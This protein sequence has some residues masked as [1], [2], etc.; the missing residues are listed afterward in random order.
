MQK[1]PEAMN[2]VFMKRQQT[3]TLRSGFAPES[4]LVKTGEGRVA[5]LLTVLILHLGGYDLKGPYALEQYY[6]RDLGG[7]Y[8]ALA[9]GPFIDNCIFSL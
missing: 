5:R 9:L 2:R 3:P 1:V 7:Y 6:A 8:R 4:A